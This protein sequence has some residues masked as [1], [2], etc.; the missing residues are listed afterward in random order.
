[1]EYI[2]SY[3]SFQML[4]SV[5]KGHTIVSKYVQTLKEAL[6]VDVIVAIY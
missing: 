2:Y 4:M 1:M 3:P 6:L 5:V